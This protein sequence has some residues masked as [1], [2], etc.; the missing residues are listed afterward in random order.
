MMQLNFFLKLALKDR[1]PS[2]SSSPT[3]AALVY[4]ALLIGAIHQI[5]IYWLPWPQ[6]NI[7][8]LPHKSTTEIG[9]FFFHI[10]VFYSSL[11]DLFPCLIDLYKNQ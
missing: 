7:L 8:M 3:T 2:L 9:L 11:I 6:S 10:P 5:T 4:F 1:L